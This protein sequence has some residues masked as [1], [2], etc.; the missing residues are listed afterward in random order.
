VRRVRGA[1][2]RRGSGRAS[3]QPYARGPWGHPLTHVRLQFRAG[4]LAQRRLTVVGQQ[5]LRG[6][7]VELQNDGAEVEVEVDVPHLCWRLG[8]ERAGS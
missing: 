7:H 1:A 5:G 6:R 8:V 2:S 3:R 4:G